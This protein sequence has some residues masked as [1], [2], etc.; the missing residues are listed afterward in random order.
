MPYLIHTHL[1]A[2]AI[3]ITL[4]CSFAPTTHGAA[5]G[6]HGMVLFENSG[7]L[8]SHMPLYQAPHNFQIILAL[9]WPASILESIQQQKAADQLITLLPNAFDLTRL[10]PNSS[11]A[12]QHIQFDIYLGHFERGGT[13]L[14][15]QVQTTIQQVLHYAPL[16]QISVN[17][18]LSDAKEIQQRAFTP[19]QWEG[20]QFLLESIR[21]R[22]AEDRIYKFHRHSSIKLPTLI[23]VELDREQPLQEAMSTWG[24]ED[25][26]LIYREWQDFQ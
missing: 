26:Q 12:L 18:S 3:F 22:P 16:P 2:I 20:Q 24:I 14:H 13:L 5:H 1:A 11:Q 19:I 15:R 21:S 25:L 9:Q 7:Q 6:R 8:A 4:M 10:S 23:E 17:S